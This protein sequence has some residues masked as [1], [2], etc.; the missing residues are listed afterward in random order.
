MESDILPLE[1]PA[2]K[3]LQEGYKAIIISGGKKII[4]SLGS[5]VG[6]LISC[7]FL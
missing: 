3:L 4:E 1:T 2:E 6:H 7:D 5:C